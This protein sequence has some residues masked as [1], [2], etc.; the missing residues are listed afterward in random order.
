MR[1][2][3]SLERLF[4]GTALHVPDLLAALPVYFLVGLACAGQYGLALA[5]LRRGLLARDGL[6][7]LLLASA[8]YFLLMAGAVGDMAT[9]R[10]RHP[11][12]P[13]I[14][15]LAGLGASSAIGRY[16]APRQGHP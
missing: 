3:L 11:A 9:G 12:M 1:G 14:C 8:V 4:S 5:G 7:V 6:T 16:R 15:V 10:M 2:S 13:A